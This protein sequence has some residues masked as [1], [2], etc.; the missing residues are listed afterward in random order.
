MLAATAVAGF[1]SQLANGWFDPYPLPLKRKRAAPAR[2]RP[3]SI[4]RMPFAGLGRRTG[5]L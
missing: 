5:P 2:G 1:E 4:G 3:K